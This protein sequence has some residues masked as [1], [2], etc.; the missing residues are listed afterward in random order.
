[1]R[2]TATRGYRRLAADPVRRHFLGRKPRER[3][4][5]HKN[6]QIPASLHKNDHPN[7]G[8]ARSWYATSFPSTGLQSPVQHSIPR[9]QQRTRI[10]LV[11]AHVL[12]YV[13]F[14]HI[15]WHIARHNARCHVSSNVP[16]QH[17]VRHRNRHDVMLDGGRRRGAAAAWRGCRPAAIAATAPPRPS[18]QDVPNLRRTPGPLNMTT[19]SKSRERARKSGVVVAARGRKQVDRAPDS[20][21]CEELPEQEIWA[22]RRARQKQ[23]LENVRAG[24]LAPQSL[25]WFAPGRARAAKLVDS[26]Y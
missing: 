8:R 20:L 18:W 5:S 14:Q 13:L 2:P 24:R 3:E 12:V 21:V 9:E 6:V 25:S 1:M 19:S 7:V 10:T 26:P 23:D 15:D 11:K 4:K 17:N 16:F 22:F